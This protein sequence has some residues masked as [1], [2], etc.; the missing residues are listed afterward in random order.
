M[1]F[2]M[3]IKKMTMSL[4]IC[5][6]CFSVTI[7]VICSCLLIV[8]LPYI[9]RSKIGEKCLVVIIRCECMKWCPLGESIT[10]NSSCV[11]PKSICHTIFSVW[12]GKVH[13]GYFFSIQV[14]PGLKNSLNFFALN[15]FWSCSCYGDINTSCC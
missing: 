2:Y 13:K 7:V 11:C 10:G 12:T 9:F 4:L 14:F 3:E 8:I 15:C 1:Y 5:I 6:M